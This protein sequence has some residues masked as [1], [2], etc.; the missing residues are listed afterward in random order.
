VVSQDEE[1]TVLALRAIASR[2]AL[3]ANALELGSLW[4]GDLDNG[5]QQIRADAARVKPERR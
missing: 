1:M 3:L 4:P 2:A 5:M